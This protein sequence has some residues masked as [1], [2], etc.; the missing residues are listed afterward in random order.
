MAQ[1]AALSRAGRTVAA[2]SRSVLGAAAQ[3]M[4]DL[5]YPAHCVTC[6][7]NL[8]E[9]DEIGLCNECRA[10]LAPPVLGWCQRCSAPLSGFAIEATQ[11]VHCYQESYPWTQAVALARYQGQLAR[12]VVRTKSP[13]N[14]PLALALARLFFD[15]RGEQLE[16][17]GSDI[18]MPIP[19]HWTRRL[20]SGANGPELVAEVLSAKLGLPLRAGW[21]KRRKLTPRQTELTR[22][23]R[24]LRQ[25]NSFRLSRRADVEGRTILLVDDVLTSGATTSEAAK[26]LLKSGAQAVYVVVIARAIGEDMP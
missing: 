1:I 5:I 10:E 14:E 17:L 21:L 8:L 7:A 13:R 22:R 12:A 19:M 9:R 3:R 20:R 25:K 4:A 23:E 26:V 16:Q 2:G 6:Q 11:C 24:L 18:V 15:R